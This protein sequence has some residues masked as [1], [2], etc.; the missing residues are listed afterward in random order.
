MEFERGE[1]VEKE[2]GKKAMLEAFITKYIN[3]SKVTNSMILDKS[4]VHVKADGKVWIGEEIKCAEF[5]ISDYFDI[6][7]TSYR[8]VGLITK[9]QA[10]DLADR[11]CFID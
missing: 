11:F 2:R 5:R 8:Q 10:E 9:E 7:I 1:V 4:G 3:G 6:L